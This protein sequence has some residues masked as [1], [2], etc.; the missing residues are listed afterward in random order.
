MELTGSTSSK[1]LKQGIDKPEAVRR[2]V[3]MLWAGFF[4]PNGHSMFQLNL[5]LI[6]FLKDWIGRCDRME[7]V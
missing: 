6:D 7:V 3:D 5:Q 4:E 2:F 1:L